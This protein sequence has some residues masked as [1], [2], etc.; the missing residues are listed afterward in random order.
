MIKGQ[1]R[2][3]IQKKK[4]RSQSLCS[5]FS[6]LPQRIGNLWY[7][8][9]VLCCSADYACNLVNFMNLRTTSNK[10]YNLYITHFVT[11][12]GALVDFEELVSFI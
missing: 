8:F 6:T 4:K 9:Y 3:K 12:G 7:H 1:K 11:S 5:V 10:K 2:E